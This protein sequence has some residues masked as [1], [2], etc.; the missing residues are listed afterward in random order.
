MRSLKRMLKRSKVSSIMSVTTRMTFSGSRHSSEATCLKSIKR[1]QRDLSTCL[2]ESRSASIKKILS[3]RTELTIWWAKSGSLTRLR[4]SST[5]AHLNLRWVVASFSLWALTPSKVSTI[6]WSN[7][8]LFRSQQEE[9]ESLFIIFVPVIATSEERM[10]FQMGSFLCCVS[11]MILLDMSIKVVASARVPSLCTWNHG[12]PMSSISSNWRRTTEKKNSALVIS[13]T[14]YGFLIS[15][16]K[17]LSITS[18]GLLCVQMNAQDSL[19]FGVKNSKPST[20]SM[21]EKVI[22]EIFSNS[23]HINK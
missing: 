23:N 3:V 7:V 12:I 22:I 6:R 17:E 21:N 5:P 18:N 10:E 1:S 2:W 15:S 14:R 16:W 8:H 11:S 4:H 9:S 13:S 20:Q 19:K